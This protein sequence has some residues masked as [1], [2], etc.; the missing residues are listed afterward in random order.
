[1]RQGNSVLLSENDNHHVPEWI[2]Q[3]YKQGIIVP[4]INGMNFFGLVYG[5]F[6][7]QDHIQKGAVEESKTFSFISSKYLWLSKTSSNRDSLNILLSDAG[8]NSLKDNNFIKLNDLSIDL[9]KETVKFKEKN[10]PVSFQEFTIIKILAKSSIVPL[11]FLDD[12]G[13]IRES[14]VYSILSKMNSFN[15]L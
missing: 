1:M 10:I 6:E 3:E 11:C 13:L 9:N 7:S 4:L 5:L 15:K 8:R 2:S 12:K 14:E